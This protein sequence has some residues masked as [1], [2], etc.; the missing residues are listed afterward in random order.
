MQYG[1]VP[2]VNKP[3]SRLVQGTASFNPGNPGECFD[4]LDLAMEYGFTT[5]DHAHCY[6][7][8]KEKVLGEWIASRGNREKLVILAKCSHPYGRDRVTPEDIE[9][10]VD[11][12]MATMGVDYFD[13]LVL[14]RDDPKVPVGPIVEKLNALVKEGRIGA[15]GGSNWTTSRV[16]AANAYAYEHGLIPFAIS[17]PNFSLAEQVEEPWS[18]CVTI[19]GPKNQAAREFYATHRDE[20]ALFTW[21]SLAGGFFSDR[22]T[23]ENVDEIADKG[24]FDSLVR[25]C[26]A[27]EPNW[28]RLD[29]VRYMAKSKGLTVPQV[30]LAYVMS[31]PMNIFALV[32]CAAREQFEA[33]NA[34][35]DVTL[36]EVE[37]AWLDLR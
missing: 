6:G 22:F 27:Y 16:Q 13:M 31:Q 2:G 37:M 23:R 33:N 4:L 35:L 15:F 12:S 11:E 10:D 3:I 5:I 26:Y 21:S 18:D 14:H 1:N 20:F 32:F 7:R 24:G 36:T 29:R 19:S 28:H 34:A 17:S 8:E 9:S 25:K 30:A